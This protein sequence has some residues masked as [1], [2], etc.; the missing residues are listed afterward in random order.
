MLYK[1]LVNLNLKWTHGQEEKKKQIL[2]FVD[3]SYVISYVLPFQVN[4][5]ETIYE[6]Y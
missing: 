4:L 1:R 5:S 2:L 3:I 6:S